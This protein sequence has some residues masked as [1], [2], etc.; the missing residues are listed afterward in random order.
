MR[1]SEGTSQRK[2]AL[3]EVAFFDHGIRPDGVHDCRLFEHLPGR[4][5]MKISKSKARD[6]RGIGFPS[7]ALSCRF[8]A[9]RRNPPNLKIR[10]S[11]AVLMVRTNLR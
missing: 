8:A 6:G 7:T 10:A 3:R 4:S 2:N 1:F 5:A 11:V 9:S